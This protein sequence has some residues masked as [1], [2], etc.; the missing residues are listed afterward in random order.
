M[1]G[2][3]GSAFPCCFASDREA[4]PKCA[5]KS[6][7]VGQ[8]ETAKRSPAGYPGVPVTDMAD[9]QLK[10]LKALQVQRVAL[11]TP[12]MEEL[13]LANAEMLESKGIRVV[14]RWAL[15]A[16]GKTGRVTMGL[17]CDELTSA[18]APSEIVAWVLQADRPEAE[19]VVIGCSALRACQAN[20]LDPLEA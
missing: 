6:A 18:V 2:G 9:A 3:L 11:L 16:M 20:F 14:N 7:Q 13:S 15:K 8:G 4:P 1:L 5:S 19:A 17:C 10:A 12:Y